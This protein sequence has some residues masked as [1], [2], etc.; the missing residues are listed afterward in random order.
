MWESH[1]SGC[2]LPAYGVVKAHRRPAAGQ[3]GS[4]RA[5][6]RD[7]GGVVELQERVAAD[8]GVD[9]HGDGHQREGNQPGLARPRP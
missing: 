9:R 1:V 7:V 2:Q 8:R 6:L 4:D 3:A 5:V